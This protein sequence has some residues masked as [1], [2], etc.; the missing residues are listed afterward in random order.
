MP[1]TLNGGMNAHL[2]EPVT[3]IMKKKIYLESRGRREMVSW[4]WK[5]A[6]M[7]HSAEAGQPWPHQC[8]KM[9]K[10]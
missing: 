6:G 9:T 2:W 10:P 5:E 7:V 3:Y 4:G 8:R 1:L